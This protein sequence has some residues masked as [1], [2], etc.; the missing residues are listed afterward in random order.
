[1][2]RPA[3]GR[4]PPRPAHPRRHPGAGRAAGRP[5][6]PAPS[7]TRGSAS[8]RRAPH[9]LADGAGRTCA[10][11]G[12]QRGR[13]GRP[14]PDRRSSSA[15]VTAPRPSSARSS[16]PASS[17]CSAARRRTR[18]C[19]CSTSGSRGSPCVRGSTTPRCGSAARRPGSGRRSAAT[20]PGSRDSTPKRACSRLLVDGPTLL[21]AR[22]RSTADAWTLGDSDVVAFGRDLDVTYRVWSPRR[23][24]PGGRWYRDF[25]T[26]DHDSGFRLVPGDLAP[27]RGRRTR[28]PTTT[29]GRGGRRRATPRTSWRPSGGGCSRATDAS[30]AAPASSSWRT[31]PS[32]SAT[33]G[34]RVRSSSE[35]VLR[36]LPAAGVRLTTLAGAIEVGHVAGRADPGPGSW[37]SG[38]DWRVWDGRGGRRRRRDE[39]AVQRRLLAIVD[40]QAPSDARGRRPELDQLA[41]DALLTL[42][43]DW[44][45]MVSHDSAVQYAR[46]RLAD[47]VAA[48]DV[49]AAAIT[50]GSPEAAVRLAAQQRTTDGPFAHLDAGCFSGRGCHSLSAP[51]ASSSCPGSTRRSST[52]DWVAT[53]TRW[54]RRR[55]RRGTRWPSSR[56]RSTVAPADSVVNG[57]RVVRVAPDPPALPDER[58]ARLGDVLRARPHPRR[59]AGGRRSPARRRPRPRLAGRAH[60]DRG[61]GART[62]SRWSPPSTRPRRGGTRAGCPAP[63]EQGRAHRRVVAD[64]R[65]PPRHHLLVAHALGGDAAVRPP[66][67]LRRRDPERHRPRPVVRRRRGRRGQARQAY[68]VRRAAARLHRTA[69]VGEGLSHA[70]R[71]AAAAAPAAPGAAAGRRR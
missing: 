11:L 67:G 40:S 30:A 1:M 31:T 53:C 52:A 10:D 7:S 68:A 66:A 16:T 62:A 8:G 59:A 69:G 21:A 57:V 55:P 64:V 17:S 27:D 18:S 37:G 25:H 9:A 43:S 54:P 5:V 58:P 49:L 63:L 19:R 36:A 26:F 46:S 38:K 48:F 28:R 15:G 71:R 29:A 47:H 45:F 6:L 44:A 14:R 4:G 22:S 12:A 33:G 13:G 35:A 56:R 2:L 32:C 34:T 65:G 51:C 70:A 39:R 23:G 42:A 41:R 3:G 24:Y 50:S 60:R 61:Q 20:G